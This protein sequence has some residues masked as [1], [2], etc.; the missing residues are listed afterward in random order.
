MSYLL[1]SLKAI[2]YFEAAARHLSFKRAAEEMSVSQGA[3]SQQ[4]HALEKF[5]GKK[6]FLRQTRKVQLTSS[7]WRLAQSASL[8]MK[9]L[10]ETITELRNE[11]LR[12]VITVHTGPY[13]SA[14]WL[15]PRLS[16]FSQRFP[17][18][19]LWMHHSTQSDP[20]WNTDIDVALL[21][22]TGEWANAIVEPLISVKMVPIC[23]PAMLSATTGLDL[24][25]QGQTP[26]LHYQN[27]Q[28]W[29]EWLYSAGL[30][31]T[32]A[33][34]GPIFDDPNVIVGAVSS[35]QGVALGFL[36]LA[37]DDLST[38]RLVIAHEHISESRFGYYIVM[39]DLTPLP[40]RVKGFRDWIIE[41]A[42]ADT[43]DNPGSQ[44]IN[45]GN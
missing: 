45:Y 14:R 23:S 16:S 5:L 41:E 11:G 2:R 10:A 21:W 38:G 20:G 32:L 30:D 24:I 25:L 18:T 42:R 44:A 1:P 37:K 8:A 13:F 9:G 17:S 27:Q 36:P 43:A 19:D 7:G 33:Q 28:A 39:R 31:S 35:G 6:L 40:P 34:K 26:L 12:E 3:I 15:S 22:G 4:I 29:S